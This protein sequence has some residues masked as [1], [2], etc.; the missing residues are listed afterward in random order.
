MGQEVI[1]YRQER[2]D[3]LGADVRLVAYQLSLR[4][5]ILRIIHGRERGMDE[6]TVPKRV[7]WLLSPMLPGSCIPLALNEPRAPLRL[8]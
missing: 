6:T 7:G 8:R 5:V 1:V 3:L 4:D 2:F